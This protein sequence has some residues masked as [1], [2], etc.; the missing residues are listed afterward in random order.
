MRSQRLAIE[1]SASALKPH[2]ISYLLLVTAA[3]GGGIMF[4]WNQPR[5][6]I[7][8]DVV[9]RVKHIELPKLYFGIHITQF[10]CYNYCLFAMRIAQWQGVELR[11]VWHWVR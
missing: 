7:Q 8:Q 11:V 5:H 2:S 3:P 4:F 10:V 9:L 1:L 6:Y